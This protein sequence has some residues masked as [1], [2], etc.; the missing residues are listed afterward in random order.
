MDR[1]IHGAAPNPSTAQWSPFALPPRPPPCIK[2]R[3]NYSDVT[4]LLLGKDGAA[5]D[6]APAWAWVW[7]L[8]VGPAR[9]CPKRPWS[10]ARRRG[11]EIVGRR[12]QRRIG[13][14][15]GRWSSEPTRWKP[16]DHVRK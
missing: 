15:C 11:Q 5:I 4:S 13:S 16:R 12:V 8:I 2:C 3:G 9:S 7:V 1:A 6:E 10:A 14:T